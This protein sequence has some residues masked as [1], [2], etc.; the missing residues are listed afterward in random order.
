MN[1]RVFVERERKRVE[2][3]LPRGASVKGL[4]ERLKINPVAVVVTVGEDVVTE[5]YQLKEKDSVEVHSVVSG[6]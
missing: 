5:E 4:L 6:G 1:V 3:E 2:V